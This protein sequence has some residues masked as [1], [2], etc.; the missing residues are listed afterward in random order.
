MEQQKR[1]SVIVPVYNVE[2][3][4]PKCLDSILA[5]TYQNL[6]IILVDDGSPDRSGEICDQYAERDSR[7]AVIHKANGGVCAA[8][9]VGLDAATGEMIG[10][11]DSDDWIEPD[12]YEV[13]LEK[14]QEHGADIVQ[15]GMESDGSKSVEEC[16]RR[17]VCMDNIE[18]WRNLY[19]SEVIG[20]VRFSERLRSSEDLLFNYQVFKRAR[21]CFYIGES[22][23]HHCYVQGSL[24]DILDDYR[25]DDLDYVMAEIRNAEISGGLR[26][27][28]DKGESDCCFSFIGS[29]VR[30]K[31]WGKWYPILRK[32]ILCHRKAI[33]QNDIYTRK[34]KMKLYLIWLC[35]P[36]YNMSIQIQRIIKRLC[37]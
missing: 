33:L 4:L 32:R 30:T 1:I 34:D 21:K 9:N 26:A 17:L 8:R 37:R 29:I 24:S 13:L 31:T 10:F 15:S 35:P 7:V 27:Y 3:Y 5:Q 20:S 22:K 6:E 14:M 28:I 11:V 18:V 25:I 16:L 19:R 23:Y 36:A 12:M 2:D